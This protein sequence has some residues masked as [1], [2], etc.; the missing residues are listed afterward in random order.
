M[1]FD[2]EEDRVHITALPPLDESKTERLETRTAPIKG[3][4]DIATKVLHV[5]D[6]PSLNACTVRMW[7]IGT[8]SQCIDSL[9]DAG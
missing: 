1:E 9:L 5:K 7:F 2:F 6:D 4:E 3:A 8:F